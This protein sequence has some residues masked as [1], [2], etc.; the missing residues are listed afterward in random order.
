MGEAD[1][2]GYHQCVLEKRREVG[3]GGARRRRRTK[4]SDIMMIW[5]YK[6]LGLNERLSRVEGR[7]GGGAREER[8]AGV[9]QPRLYLC[10]CVPFMHHPESGV[11]APAPE[12]I[13]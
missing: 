8:R 5:R 1:R 9:P 10:C 2:K 4:K 11:S 7:R 6:Q 13:N 3:E 12:E